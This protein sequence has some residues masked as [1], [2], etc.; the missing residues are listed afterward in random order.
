MVNEKMEKDYSDTTF[1]TESL[2][3]F[4][5]NYGNKDLTGLPPNK[6]L[7]DAIK[8][9]GIDVSGS[10]ALEVGCGGGMNLRWLSVKYMCHC[11]GVEP[12]SKLIEILS[13]TYKNIGFKAASSN[14]LPFETNSFDLVLL[15]SVLHWIDRNFILQ[16]LGEAIRV[17]RK[18]IIISDYCPSIPYKVP[19]K[20]KKDLFTWKI[21]YEQLLLNTG[22]LDLIFVHMVGSHVENG[23]E[24]ALELDASTHKTGK[25]DWNCI[26]TSIF[27]KDVGLFPVHNDFSDMSKLKNGREVDIK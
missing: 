6:F 3:Y 9:S 22:I 24:Q 12:S 17:S 27:R 14:N 10:K 7:V 2:A 19:Y 21:D 13:H 11:F 18:W 4:E 23:Q 20:Y 5:R 1:A 16:S 25:Y 8:N 15:R 26:K